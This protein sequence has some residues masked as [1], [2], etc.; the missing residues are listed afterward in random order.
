MGKV[1]LYFIKCCG[2]CNPRYSIKEIKESIYCFLKENY[3]NK[4]FRESRE[5]EKADIIFLAN[6]CENNCLLKKV[7]YYRGFY[8][9]QKIMLVLC[10]YDKIIV[11]NS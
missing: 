8:K 2:N 7:K 4:K 9:K 1:L 3:N 5:I 10:D 11:H 6:A